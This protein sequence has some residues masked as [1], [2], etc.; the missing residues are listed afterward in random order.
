M[1]SLGFCIR[2]VDIISNHFGEHF[3]G[4]IIFLKITEYFVFFNL[5]K[6]V[7]IIQLPQQPP[8]PAALFTPFPRYIAESKGAYSK[9]CERVEKNALI[10]GYTD[11]TPF[12]PASAT[13][14][15]PPFEHLQ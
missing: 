11:V 13:L 4:R 12:C 3:K 14:R 5:S 7:S 6:K 9:A 1:F 15:M 8:Y 10:S 2:I